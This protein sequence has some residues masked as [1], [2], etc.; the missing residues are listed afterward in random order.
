MNRN[1]VYIFAGNLNQFHHFVKR[2][3]NTLMEFKRI[4][5]ASDLSGMFDGILVLVGTAIELPNYKNVIRV[6]R[7]R[8]FKIIGNT[9]SRDF[10]VIS[11][12]EL[13]SFF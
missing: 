4:S 12:N 11:E 8:D 9:C 1:I 3:H 10:K 7:S 2:N 13:N 6:A 5:S